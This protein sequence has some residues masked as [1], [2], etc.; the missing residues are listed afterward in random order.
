MQ[1]NI[2]LSILLWIRKKILTIICCQTKRFCCI[3]LLLSLLA[4]VCSSQCLPWSFLE[5]KWDLKNVKTWNNICHPQNILLWRYSLYFFFQILCYYSFKVRFSHVRKTK[6]ACSYTVFSLRR[7]SPWL[8]SMIYAP[9]QLCASGG[10]NVFCPWYAYSA[11]GL[12]SFQLCTYEGCSKSSSTT[13]RNI[14]LS[15]K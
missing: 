9:W 5:I 8:K 7:F 1:E 14:V 3:R 2:A 11:L 15:F 12:C 13:R 6:K 10:A 4:N